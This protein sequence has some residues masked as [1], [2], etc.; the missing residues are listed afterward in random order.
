MAKVENI[1]ETVEEPTPNPYNAKKS[2]H[3]EDVMP[4]E[5]L[6]ADSLFVAPRP[7]K[8][9]GDQQIEEQTATQNKPY[10]QPNYKKRY[11]DLKKHYDTKLNEFR[12]REQ[13]LANKVQQAQPVYEAPKSLEELERFKSE[14]PD[15]YEVVE[16]VAHLKSEDKIKGLTDKVALIEARE[17]D[18]MRR[19]A[20]KD[21]MEKHPDYSDL[22]NND[23]FHNWA[24]TQ[25]EEIQ[26]WIYNNPNNAS[27]ASKAIDLYKM[28]VG[29]STSVK[30]QKPSSNRQAQASE[31]VSTK[32]TSVEAKEPKI[33]TQEEI[34][35]LPM[36]E[37]DRLESEIDRALDEGRVRN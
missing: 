13:E 7:E 17:Q 6:S 33:W 21:L 22:R 36:D 37:F 16:S 35:A 5:G 27:L 23:A 25:P 4:K 30:Q 26:D 28:E 31:M 24:E 12:T 15:V 1:Q 18:I 14:Y 8:D 20:E 2:W 11:D 19:E 29:S 9:E 34:A 3:T 32:T 10:S